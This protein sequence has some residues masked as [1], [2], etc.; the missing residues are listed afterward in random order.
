MDLS[1]NF[2]P[3][4]SF[5]AGLSGSLH[6][7][8]MCGG[9]VSASCSGGR[10]IL[11]YQV[12]RLFGYLVLASIVWV[13][14]N[15]FKNAISFSWAPFAT[16]MIMGVT[17]IYWGIQNFQG[18]KAEIRVPGF[19]NNSYRFLFRKF[20]SKAT[21]FRSLVIGLISIMLPCGLLYG[22][23]IAALALGTYEQIIISLFFFW[24]GTLP[25]MIGAP[26]LLKKL[27]G[28]L[29]KKL[30]RIYALLFIVIGV[31]TIAGRLQDL[32]HKMTSDSSPKTEVKRCH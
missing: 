18:K 6:C 14:G 16:G 29:R 1:S 4:A 30:P 23:I 24:L 32:P 20:V 21:V 2:L 22:L 17:F 27:L 13:I 9:L 19:L 5:I 25:A 8:G 10:D 26:Q 7:L 11:K 15:A 28:P 3:Y 31:S 12:G